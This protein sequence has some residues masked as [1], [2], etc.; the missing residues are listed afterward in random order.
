M[1]E[2]RM[3]GCHLPVYG[4]DIVGHE[5]ELR[6]VLFGIFLVLEQEHSQPIF[7]DGAKRMIR[8][9]FVISDAKFKTLDK[10]SET[11]VDIRVKNIRD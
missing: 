7:L 9:Q 6:P 4:F 11:H 3:G 2:F 8:M 10:K 1:Q 5:P